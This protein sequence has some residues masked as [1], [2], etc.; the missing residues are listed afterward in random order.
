M[1]FSP[2]I[3]G[4]M[5]VAGVIATAVTLKRREPPIFPITL[6]Y[7]TAMEALQFGGY[8]VIN[9]CGTPANQSIT[10]L[11][12]LHIVFQ[13][14]FINAFA[15]AI[16]PVA[17]GPRMR[18]LAF[19]ICGLSAAVML[20]QLYPFAWAGTCRPG[21]ILCGTPLCTVSGD[22]H[23]AWNVPYN[24]LLGGLSRM[25]VEF[26]TYF[27]AAFFV[28][29]LYGA[30]RFVIFHAL[31]GPI[32]ASYLTTNPNE[33]PAIWCLVSIGIALVAMSPLIRRQ[34]APRPEPAAA[35]S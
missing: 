35:P 18:T 20:M 3:T 15:M 29:L 32:A 19:G 23:L 31:V 5:V 4:A 11:S 22:W 34:L 2:T 33:I 28:P 6:A 16:L 27:I 1:C 14:F 7:F 8:M 13:P 9:Q 24:D 10:F 30:W 21:S 25:T 26:P 17:V 12:I